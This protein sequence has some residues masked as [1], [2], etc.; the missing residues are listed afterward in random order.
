MKSTS[1][2]EVQRQTESGYRNAIEELRRDPENGF[3]RLEEIGAVR[4]V[5]W[6]ERATIIAKAW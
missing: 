3:Q 5:S 1:L 4:E 6:N 2:R